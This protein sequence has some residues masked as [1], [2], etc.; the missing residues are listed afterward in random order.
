MSFIL[1]IVFFA[2]IIGFLVFIHELGHFLAAKASG[3][4]VNEF[5]IGFGPI[6]I[7]KKYKETDYQLRLL[8]I[9]GFVAMEGE[10]DRSFSS[11]FRDRPF[12]TKALI[13]LGGIIMNLI[14]AVI[15]LG[16]YQSN[17]KNLILPK[18]YEYTFTNTQSQGSTTPVFIDQINNQWNW[19][20]DGV[21]DM[22]IV[23]IEGKYINSQDD[24]YNLIE[25]FEGKEVNADFLNLENQTIL[26][27]QIKIGTPPQGYDY[28]LRVTNV[29]TDGNSIDILK[30]EELIYAVDSSIITSF[31]DF[32]T[33]RDE[34][35][36][37]QKITINTINS[38]G[39]KFS[40]EIIINNENDKSP[41]GIAIE[42]YY[43][44]DISYLGSQIYIVDYQDSVTTPISFTYDMARYQIGA[45]ANIIS[46]AF[47]TGDF[48]QLG[49]SVG[50][51][52]AVSNM[53]NI[54][55]ERNLFSS[56][57]FLAGLLSLSLGIFNL[58]PIPAL[59]GGQLAIAYIETLRKKHINDEIVN[60][61]NFIGF[62]VLMGLSFIIF[63]KDIFQ[64]EVFNSFINLFQSIFGR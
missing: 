18:I 25:E 17:N 10:Q 34:S 55:V 44:L 46:R 12:K 62:V 54:L 58:L 24:L 50:G 49:E 47:Q 37:D 40:K 32:K 27:K 43:G 5:A 23:S 8:P 13:L 42:P 53:V 63:L 15:L 28:L 20:V 4:K 3:V 11:G 29:F 64:F 19:E 7:S 30:E 48:Q 35:L 56:M 21:E 39:E 1:T 16:I 60:K 22:P 31:E 59:D 51:P 33:K 6:I 9:G 41:L 36:I 38:D 61:I 2:L 14:F 57:V 45:L 26:T 52:V